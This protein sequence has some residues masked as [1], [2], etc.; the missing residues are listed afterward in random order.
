MAVCDTPAGQY[1]YYGK[2]HL[3]ETTRYLAFDPAVFVN[4]DGRVWLYYGSAFQS[5]KDVIPV[6]GGAVVELAQDMKTVLTPA[7]ANSPES[8]PRGGNEFR[9]TPIL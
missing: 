1:Q 4:D 8:D 3:P 6:Q 5:P 2:V 9:Q 7:E